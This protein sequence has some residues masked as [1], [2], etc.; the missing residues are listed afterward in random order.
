MNSSSL[1]G[2]KNFERNN[3][4]LKFGEKIFLH[5]FE[6][7]SI[8]NSEIMISKV[9]IASIILGKNELVFNIHFSI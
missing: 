5:N 3:N 9:V 2:C 6:N 4:K 8:G 7:N 1:K